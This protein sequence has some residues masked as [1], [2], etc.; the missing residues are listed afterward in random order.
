MKT[1]AA[2]INLDANASLGPLPGLWTEVERRLQ[3]CL[4]PSSIH[5]PGQR[6]RALIEEAR[7]EI[8]ALLNV[9]SKSKVVFTSGATEANALA[10]AQAR[11]T[12]G[13]DAITSAIEHPSVLHTFSQL[14]YSAEALRIVAPLTT[15]VINPE[16]M[17]AQLSDKTTLVSL[18]LANNETGAVQP[19]QT[20]SRCVK[21]KFPKVLVHSDAVQAVGK[22]KVSF[23]DLGVDM[24]SISGHKIGAFPGVGALIL[25]PGLEITPIL[26]GGPQETRLRAGT[27]NLPG[28]VSLGIAAQ[29]AAREFDVRVNTWQRQKFILWNSIKENIPQATATIGSEDALPNTLHLIFPGLRADDLVVALDLA[30]IAASTGAACA[31]G[32]IEPSHV[33]L[34]MQR[35]EA[36]ARSSLRLSL[37]PDLTD[38]QVKGTIDRMVQILRRMY[39]ESSSVNPTP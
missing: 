17:L 7:G 39:A 37:A 22:I 12:Q 29:Y 2:H 32:K 28:I 4:N 21:S 23:I 24:L 19:V 6:S 33:L 1:S 38:E 30:G 31:S 13:W 20:L 35:S 15:G 8:R 10:L 3:G 34:A 9:P 25:A 18:M 27:E 11:Q 16:S 36:Q 5:T 26:F 14:K